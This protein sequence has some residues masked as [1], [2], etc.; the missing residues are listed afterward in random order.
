MT[1]QMKNRGL[2]RGLGALLQDV[3]KTAE[4][5]YA[6]MN[7]SNMNEVAIA[8]IVTNPYQPRTHFDA[9]AL[10]EL[11]E[12]IKV[13]GII[14]PITL[15]QIDKDQYQL[16]SGE[17]RLQASKLAGLTT[18]PAYIRTANDQQMLEMALIE[19]IQRENLNAIEIALTYQRMMAELHLKADELGDR[20][21]K[22]RSTVT[23]FL[24]ILKLPVPIQAG[25]RDDQISMGHARSLL[26]VEDQ[27]MQIALYHRCVA[28]AWSVRRTE[29]A[30]KELSA[31]KTKTEKTEKSTF[32]NYSGI[33]D[34]LSKL[35]GTKVAISSNAEGRG[36]IKIPFGTET[37]LIK[38]ISLIKM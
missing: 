9:Q 32:T 17:R 31:P 28:E 10:A 7:P 33:S 36:E 11:A 6:A 15:R 21:G 14:Q 2:G 34:K 30:V 3:D 13:Q 5:D 38:I 19:N 4:R 26:G 37:E 27:A 22:N 16:I 29:E 24:R 8:Q 23:N 35:L 1:A 25:L 12:S 18:I 20:V